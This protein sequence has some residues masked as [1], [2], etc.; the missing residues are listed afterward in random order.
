MNILTVLNELIIT[1]D[2]LKANQIRSETNQSNSTRTNRTHKIISSKLQSVSVKKK[3]EL[4]VW[5][6]VDL[7]IC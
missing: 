6:I 3:N 1:L 2:A 4:I 5:P 7:F